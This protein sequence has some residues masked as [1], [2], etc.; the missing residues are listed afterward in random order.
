MKS[1]KVPLTR[2]YFQG[3][4]LQTL[5]DV[6][7]SEWL[8]QGSY[9]T[10]FED[11][12]AQYV[13][14]KHAVACTSCT[15]A[16]HI[17]LLLQGVGPGDEVIVPSYT[18]I[19]TAN[20]VRMVGAIP[21][22]VD[23]DLSTFNIAPELI[24]AA[25]THFTK[26]IIPV[27]QFGLPADMDHISEIA[28]RHGLAVVEDAACALGSQYKGKAIGDLGNLTCLSFHPRKVIT[29]GEGGMLLTDDSDISQRARVLINHGGS[30]SNIAKHK[31]GTVEA[32]L[33][34]EFSE[35]GFN[36]RMTNLQGAF[37]TAQVK[38][39]ND[40]LVARRK[41]VELYNEAFSKIPYIITPE[42]PGYAQHNWQTYAIRV[43]QNSPIN[44]DALAQH[45]LDAGISCRPA[46]IAC[47][48][49]PVYRSLFPDLSLPN[50]ERA[51]KEVLI[52]PLYPQMTDKEQDY[53]TETIC[54]L[55]R[56]SPILG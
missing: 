18:W 19:A 32:L 38:A 35:V 24:E 7:D 20:V 40:I 55:M 28:L 22:F 8:T 41:L 51:L 36:Y 12:V 29:T 15:T 46:Y 13:G 5:S 34:E 23:I 9:V 10:D 37:G 17:S 30:V 26:A 54:S 2:P 47:H 21:V 42:V 11:S 33:A 49:Q 4:E 56:K 43:A 48:M 44:R 52:L 3:E 50:T 39:L 6:L 16:L 53:V 31:A 45:L 25:I 1:F 27:H 14:V